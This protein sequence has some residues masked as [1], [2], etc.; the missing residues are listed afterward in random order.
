[1]RG[2]KPLASWGL[3]SA[4]YLPAFLL[5]KRQGSTEL[6][7]TLQ[8]RSFLVPRGTGEWEWGR[9]LS[10]PHC[11]V[12]VLEGTWRLRG[13]VLDPNEGF[14]IAALCQPLL[15]NILFTAFQFWPE[16]LPRSG[17]L[18]ALLRP[19][20]CA[21]LTLFFALLGRGRVTPQSNSEALCPRAPASS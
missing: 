11:F 6:K 7:A 17:C 18:E 20:P 8:T 10:R 14:V 3:S 4:F 5:F 15:A 9:G 21:T 16:A 19:L 13:V 12:W 1:M 2:A